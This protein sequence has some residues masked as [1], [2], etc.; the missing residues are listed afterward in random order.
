MVRLQKRYADR[1]S[2]VVCNAED[3]QYAQYV[4]L[5]GVDGIPHLALI[6]GAA[7]GRKL[8]GTLI[9]EIPESVRCGHAGGS[10]KSKH[11]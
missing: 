3:P 5:F 4:R 2:F 10:C 7:G 9:G 8:R 1:V 6:D 11:A